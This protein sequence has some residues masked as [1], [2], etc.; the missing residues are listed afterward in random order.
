MASDSFLRVNLSGREVDVDLPD[1][2]SMYS[3]KEVFLLDDYY[4]LV[5]VEHRAFRWD[6][7]RLLSWEGT[8]VE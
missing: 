2:L 4:I 6:S 7:F 1:G 3:G 8:V 5:R